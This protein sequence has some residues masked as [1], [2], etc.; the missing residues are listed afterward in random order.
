MTGRPAGPDL[1]LVGNLIVDD[2]VLEDGSTRLAEPG[3]A[4]L[5]A[6]LGAALWP[7]RAGVVS[8]HGT[9]YPAW[10]LEALADRGV[11]LGGVRCDGE[12]AL[13]G[14]LIYEGGRRRIV[15]RD[16][17]PS[18]ADASP[19]PAEVPEAWLRS[20]RLVHVS[21]M[22]F[23]AQAAQVEATAAVEG[24]AVSLD[25]HLAI[26]ADTWDAWLGILTR[27]DYLFLSEDDVHPHVLAEEPEALLRRLVTTPL[28]SPGAA[29]PARRLRLAA[30]KR[31][32]RGGSALDVRSG[33]TLRWE[34]R[35]TRVVDPT[36]AG[37][38]FAA[39]FLAGSLNGDGVERALERA[40]V[41]ASFAL[42]GWGPAGLLAAT[43]D[44]AAERLRAWF[45]D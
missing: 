9:D 10:A 25:P 37:D 43:R 45:G 15:H 12:R 16:D 6:A 30:F 2:M 5:Y 28:P 39:G 21:P 41:T 20:A 27:L 11:D 34:P 36:G 35:A 17:G 3:G 7:V 33:R 26:G 40:V 29:P 23:E 14:W 32:E 18:H 44:Q 19:S 1:V 24:L 22:P 31:G 13:R 8:R 42:E 38:A 4:T